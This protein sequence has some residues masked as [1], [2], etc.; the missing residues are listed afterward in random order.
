MLRLPLSLDLLPSPCTLLAAGRLSK[1]EIERMVQ[2]AEKYASEDESHRKRVEVCARSTVQ[3]GPAW[4][5]TAQ[6]EA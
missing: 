5:G 3:H 2:E 6:L 4:H 1:D